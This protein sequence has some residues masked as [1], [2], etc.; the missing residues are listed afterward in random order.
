M[1]ALLLGY[2]RVSTDEQD[3]AAHPTRWPRSAS[4]PSA[5]TSITA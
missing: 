2:A 5:S 3:L 4:A 1:S